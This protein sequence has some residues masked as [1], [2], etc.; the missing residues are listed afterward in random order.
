MF[1]EKADNATVLISSN[2]GGVSVSIAITHAVPSQTSN[3]LV[4]FW[5][6]T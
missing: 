2:P 6:I 5:K 1:V 4:S 3:W